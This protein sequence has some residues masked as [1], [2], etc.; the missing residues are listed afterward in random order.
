M[1]NN[2]NVLAHHGLQSPDAGTDDL[3]W[4]FSELQ[5]ALPDTGQLTKDMVRSQD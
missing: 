5:R 2:S 4:N 1:D 3:A